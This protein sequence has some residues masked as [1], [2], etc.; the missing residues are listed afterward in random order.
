MINKTLG[1]EI[2]GSDIITSDD[3]IFP[4]SISKPNLKVNNLKY[5]V[6]CM[7]FKVYNFILQYNLN[8][9]IQSYNLSFSI[10]I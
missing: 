6:R 8:H 10:M 3:I 1:L 4:S 5:L 7:Y 9:Y 2:I